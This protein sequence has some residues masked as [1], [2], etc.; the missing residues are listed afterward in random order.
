[1]PMDY[2]KTRIKSGFWVA[3]MGFL[4]VLIGLVIQNIGQFEIPAPWDTVLLII[5]TAILSQIS[6]WINTKGNQSNFM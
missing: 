5:L 6:K 3:A 1:M 4:A 2:L